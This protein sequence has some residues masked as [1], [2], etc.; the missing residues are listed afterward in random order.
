M[1]DRVLSVTDTLDKPAA[2]GTSAGALSVAVSWIA[3]LE[4]GIVREP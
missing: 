4:A 2:S 3:P 1:A